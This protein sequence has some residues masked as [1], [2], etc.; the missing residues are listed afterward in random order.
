MTKTNTFVSNMV[1]GQVGRM[2]ELVLGFLFNVAVIRQ[3][4]VGDYGAYSLILNIVATVNYFTALGLSESLT[5]FIPLA[6]EPKEPYHYSLLRRFLLIR[7][8]AGVGL[9]FGLLVGAGWLAQLFDAPEINVYG[10]ILPLLLLTFSLVDLFLHFYIASFR[11]RETAWAR[12]LV[13]LLTLGGILVW[14]WLYSPGLLAVLIVTLLSNAVMCAFYLWRLPVK[15]LLNQK[16]LAE[17]GADTPAIIRYSR[18]LW[19][20]SFCNFGISGWIDV[21][22]IGIILNDQTQVAYYALIIMLVSRV[23]VFTG[24]WTGSVSSIAASVQAEKGEEGLARY[25]NYFYK[26]NL[27]PNLFVFGYFMA[28]GN[29]LIINLFTARY[30][31][32]VIILLIYSGFWLSFGFLA[33]NIS[34]TFANVIGKQNQ[35]LRVRLL[36]S[37][38]SVL[39]EIVLLIWIGLI[40]AVIAT[41]IA[42]I[43][44]QTVEV[45]LIRSLVKQI[46]L[47]FMLKISV[48]TIF[49]VLLSFWLAN[50]TF[51]GL[52]LASSV[53]SVLWLGG[54]V[55]VK[56]LDSNDRQ[57]LL[58]WRSGLAKFLKFL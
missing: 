37:V 23:A 58:N 29:S 7:L 16:S 1:W 49:A 53:Y 13:Q 14:F 47:L 38:F 9:G 2:S 45:Y 56:P 41:I 6:S 21:I 27:L 26:L 31:P 39:L 22:L 33:G 48:I 54:L 10:W 12:P 40:G 28:A 51:I 36:F 5:R 42:T 18:D 8:L 46:P 50:N 30:E 3:L 19:L 25:F 4:S 43:L 34:Q 11:L 15:R 17:S 44:T 57:V 55:L 24:G 35:V 32:S 52:I 20:I